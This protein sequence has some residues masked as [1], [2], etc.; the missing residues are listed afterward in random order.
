MLKDINIKAVYN[1]ED[2][3]ILEDFYIPALSQSIAYDR[4]VGYFDAKMLTSAASGL[5]EFITHNG[6]MKLICGST[7]TEDEYTAISE[8]YDQREIKDRISTTFT[9]IVENATDALTQNQLKTLT[10]MVK[11][12]N[13]DVKIALRRHGIHHQKIGVFYDQNGDFIC[14]QGSANETKNALLPYNYET[15]NVFKSWIPGFAEHYEP[16]I[17]SFKKLWEN[18]TKNTKVLNISDI[19]FEV[20]TK[21]YPDV[22]R[23]KIEDE[24]KLWQ[25][26]LDN[27][28]Q[29]ENSTN[30]YNGTPFVPPKIG[31][32]DFKLHSHQKVALEKWQDNSFR[33]VFELATGAG[34]TITA[35]VGAVRT[36]ETRKRLFLVIAVPYQNLADQWAENLSLF[37]IQPTICYGG[38]IKWINELNSKVL[39]F[40][41]G[42]ID[43]AA[44][45]VV[46][47]TMTSKK[48]T[49]KEII[50]TIDGDLSKYFMFVGDECHHHGAFFTHKALPKQADLRMG[51]SA[52]P[53]RGEEDLGN[54]LIYDFY[55]E[56]I[57]SYTLKDALNDGVLTPYDY[58]VIP[59]ILTP[60]ETEKYIELSKKI[61]RLFA[62]MKSGRISSIEDDEANLNMLRLKRARIVYGSENKPKALSKLLKTINKPIK[63]SLFYCAEGNID[64]SEDLPIKQISLV[65]SILHENGWKTSQFT[66]NE[67]KRRRSIILND[68]K[69]NNIDALVAM[70]CLDE[71]VDIPLCST[72]FILSSTSKERQFIQRRGRILRKSDGK[73]KALIYDFVIALP[74][75]QIQDFELGR[76]LMISELQ[77]INEFAQLSLNKSEAYSEISEYL[78][79]Y[80]LFHHTI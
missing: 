42:L 52:T 26:S 43:F 15:I 34:K 6:K 57:H 67:G 27:E 33:G 28:D 56:I 8:G 48:E 12:G 31:G 75:N 72:A 61:S 32:K 77:R 55:G 79:K 70:K 18:K 41:A 49:F 24:I 64:N 68:F 13:L 62:M 5:S 35:I 80:D 22:E 20:L 36:F 17:K 46:D 38:E 16:H 76:K 10:W 54:E 53:D 74:L 50:S 60:D 58:K 23:P 9:E 19:T 29:A 47:A 73:K 59:V 37:N 2:D 4:A 11:N 44:V 65:S 30:R 66:S 63:H 40:K 69:K 3:N 51:L 71:G 39:N 7:L 45:I 78:E 21:K 14:F 25:I 1:S